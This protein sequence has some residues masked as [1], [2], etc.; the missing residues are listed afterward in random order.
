MLTG[1]A[2][3]DTTWRHMDAWIDQWSSAADSTKREAR[4][5]SAPRSGGKSTRKPAS[6]STRKPASADREAIGANPTRRY[7]SAGSRALSR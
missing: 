4:K 6:A 5:Q 3:R 1:R 7:G 2:A